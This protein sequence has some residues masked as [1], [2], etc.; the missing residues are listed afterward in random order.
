MRMAGDIVKYGSAV[1]GSRDVRPDLSD[2]AVEELFAG[3]E[4]RR[5]VGVVS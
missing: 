1:G 3:K 2:V 4:A 5:G